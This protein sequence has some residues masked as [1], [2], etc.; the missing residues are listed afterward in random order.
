M[1]ANSGIDWVDQTFD[2]CVK[3]LFDTAHVM[4]ITYEEINVWIFCVLWPIATLVL[5]AEIFRLR[6]KLNK[7]KKTGFIKI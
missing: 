7:Q 5:F 3:L 6:F 1:R 4:G 2:F